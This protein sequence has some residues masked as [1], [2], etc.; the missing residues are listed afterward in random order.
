MVDS[1]NTSTHFEYVFFFLLRTSLL[2]EEGELLEE[3][4][5]LNFDSRKQTVKQH[6]IR[7][8]QD[9]RLFLREATANQSLDNWALEL[10]AGWQSL[11]AL[12]AEQF[13][14]EEQARHYCQKALLGVALLILDEGASVAHHSVHIT[15]QDKDY[16][17]LRFNK[18]QSEEFL[19]NISKSGEAKQAVLH[20]FRPITPNGRP[21]PKSLQLLLADEKP[22]L[23]PMISGDFEPN[24][25]FL[26]C[27]FTY[28]GND[29]W[30]NAVEQLLIQ[31]GPANRPA[32]L[33]TIFARLIMGHW[34]FGR[35][36]E[37][38]KLWRSKLQQINHK[39][40][41]YANQDDG[42]RPP[43]TRTRQLERQLQEMQA[44]QN[45]G[46]LLMSRLQ[47]ALQTLDVNGDNL[48]TRLE[49][50]RQV[51]TDWQIRFDKSGEVDKIK[52]PPNN[53]EMPLLAS[54]NLTINKLKDHVIYLKQ[55]IDYLEGLQQQWLLFLR[56]RHTL[57]GEQLNT[58]ITL[59]ILLFAGAGATF[60]IN[61]GSLGIDAE[62]QTLMFIILAVV[63]IPIV[64]HF[65]GWFWRQL[66]CICY[67]TWFNKFL[68]HNTLFDKLRAIEFFG[69]FKK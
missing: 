51:Q 4:S 3:P 48:A 19:L 6:G 58:L 42:A 41:N 17:V 33:A 11:E 40:R 60:S 44:Y 8:E 15:S 28:G 35:M 69:W 22:Q 20:Q 54:F 16:Q 12:Y 23:A 9:K 46:R 7:F 24:S 10:Q 59:F 27:G 43:C 29:D 25:V 67:G 32:L 38:A 26:V 30:K 21:M 47:G 5:R 2:T 13:D 64:W 66:C 65:L 39:Y 34:Q 50:I 53:D 57:S 49:Q 56:K 31:K 45:E 61:R 36:N 55:Q 68:C 1:Q 52:W 18:P 63:L 62:N 14:S 37:E